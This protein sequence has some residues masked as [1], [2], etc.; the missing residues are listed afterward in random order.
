[1]YELPSGPAVDPLYTKNSA[2]LRTARDT[3]MKST[4]ECPRADIKNNN[5]N[6]SNNN[7]N[8][9]ELYLPMMTISIQ[10]CKSVESKIISYGNLVIR[11]QSQH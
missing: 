10:N 9:S 4:H 8:N 11:E 6:N 5:N 3:E 2:F 1:M 7:N